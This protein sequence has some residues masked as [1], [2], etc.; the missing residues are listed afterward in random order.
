MNR[1]IIIGNGFDLASGLQSGYPSFILW[2][3][4][5][6]LNDNVNEENL[7]TYSSINDSVVMYICKAETLNEF[8]IRLKANEI[9]YNTQQETDNF[10]KEIVKESVIKN[11]VDIES[12]YINHLIKLKETKTQEELKNGLIIRLNNHLYSIGLKLE[13]YLGANL[14]KLENID[15]DYSDKLKQLLFCENLEKLNF[16]NGDFNKSN[17]LILNFN[18]TNLTH[19]WAYE[20]ENTT[21]I[22]IHG[23]LNNEENK[24]I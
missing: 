16:G 19:Q 6:C 12:L 24:I 18:Y 17:T 9:R 21:Q 3:L 1:L 20:Q 23:E 13:E 11:W 22:N 10:L 2:Y 14:G 8:F 15:N 7:Y 4:K 5:Q